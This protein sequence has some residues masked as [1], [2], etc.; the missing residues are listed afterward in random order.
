LAVSQCSRRARFFTTWFWRSGASRPP[1]RPTSV[2]LGRPSTPQARPHG[3]GTPPC[4]RRSNGRRPRTPRDRRSGR[5]NLSRSATP[6]AIPRCRCPR[7]CVPPRRTGPSLRT[8]GIR[9][10]P[11]P[12]LLQS[13][14]THCAVAPACGRRPPSVN[15]CQGRVGHLPIEHSLRIEVAHLLGYHGWNSREGLVVHFLRVWE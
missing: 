13:S 9:L 3:S 6:P 5:S 12:N 8:C 1:A 2:P 14:W 4:C 15:S 7:A 11:L 10:T